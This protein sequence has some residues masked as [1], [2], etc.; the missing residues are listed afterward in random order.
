MI[1]FAAR[2]LATEFRARVAII[3]RRIRTPMRWRVAVHARTRWRRPPRGDARPGATGDVSCRGHRDNDPGRP[4]PSTR[5]RA[6]DSGLLEPGAG[7]TV[8]ATDPAVRRN[9]ALPAK[10]WP[11]DLGDLGVRL[12]MLPTQ[13]YDR[14]P[15]YN[16]AMR[17]SPQDC[18]PVSS[19]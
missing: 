15:P 4:G 8:A 11:H 19:G 16:F 10:N 3:A 6:L 9:I 5:G 13:W 1:S 14:K 18:G 7:E 17:R 2:S 12:E